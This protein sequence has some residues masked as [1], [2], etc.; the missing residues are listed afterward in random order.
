MPDDLTSR[1][2]SWKIDPTPSR[3]S[4][5]LEALEPT[6]NSE[7]QRYTGPKPV[8]KSRAKTLAVSAIK[9]YDPTKGTQLRSWVVSNMQPLSRFSMSL[10]PI[11]APEVAF[12]Q[13]ADVNRVASELEMDLGRQPTEEELADASGLSIK[14]IKHIRER[15]KG[16]ATESAI[17][18]D[19][20]NELTSNAPAV[21]EPNKLD[22][23]KDFV[24]ASLSD[25]DKRIFE[26]KTGKNGPELSNQE[27]AR[28]L[29]VSPA[30]V[31]QRSSAIAD[32]IAS[33]SQKGAL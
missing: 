8:L 7:I 25:R 31:S 3:L 10:R 13:A 15:V 12:R 11:A 29:G 14:R 16:F 30:F 21:F 18:G 22:L 9:S 6:I 17:M 20:A 23:A 2:E 26:W 27:I 4:G 1:F 19:A 28:R 33:V 5:V 32:Q 24:Y